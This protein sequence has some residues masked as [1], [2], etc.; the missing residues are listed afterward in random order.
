MAWAMDRLG[1]SLADLIG[2][3]RE[4]EAARVRVGWFGPSQ[5]KG[6]RLGRP[7]VGSKTEAAIRARLATGKGILRVAKEL[8]VGTGTV[9]RVKT[10][11]A[12]H[13]G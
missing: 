3:L 4:V 10:Q 8:G 12:A 6:V 5:G 13:G 7:T 11:M 9:Q 2:T 1:R